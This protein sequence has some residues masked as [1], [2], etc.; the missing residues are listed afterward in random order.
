MQAKTGG[1]RIRVPWAREAQEQFNKYQLKVHQDRQSNGEVET[2]LLES[3]IDQADEKELK[4]QEINET[5][6]E[7]N[8]R[9][10]AKT[11]IFDEETENLE[12]PDSMIAAQYMSAME[13][14]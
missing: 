4:R 6:N 1:K 2:R 14:V 10:R 5:V 13:E 9:K 3:M 11:L 7:W 8:T 12:V